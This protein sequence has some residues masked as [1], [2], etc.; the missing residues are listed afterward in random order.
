MTTTISDA[1]RAILTA[2]AAA[3]NRL[4][5]PAHV[6]LKGGAV[7]IVLR[8]LLKRRL[9]GEVEGADGDPVWSS[10]NAGVQMALRVTDAGL[11]AVGLAKAPAPASATAAF[12]PAET[13]QPKAVRAGTK[14]AALIALLERKEGATIDEMVAATG[15]LSHTVRG[16]MAG[17]L[18]KRLGMEIASEKVEG[19]GRVYRVAGKGGQ[20]GHP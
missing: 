4:V 6:P 17:A 1:Q 2:A 13:A 18:K 20:T 15:W 3:D 10:S 19:R 16:A 14:Q 7:R 5:Q 9:L 11:Q 12:T 8:S